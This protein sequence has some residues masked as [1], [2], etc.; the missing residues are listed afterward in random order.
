MQLRARM[1]PYK[2]ETCET[3]ETFLEPRNIRLRQ[4]TYCLCV[5]RLIRVGARYGLRPTNKMSTT[6]GTVSGKKFP[7]EKKVQAL[8]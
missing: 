7:R 5:T 8:E 4:I 6:T 3:N 1:L 2:T